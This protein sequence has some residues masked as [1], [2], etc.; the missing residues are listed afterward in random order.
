MTELDTQAKR[1]YE[2]EANALWGHSCHHVPLKTLRA[3]AK[4]ICID[5][6]IPCVTVHV[7]HAKDTTGLYDPNTYRI[8]LEASSGRNLLILAH[9]LA[10]HL[11]W[12]NHPHAQSH[13]PIWAKYYM[14][15]LDALYIMPICAFKAMARQY[16]V[17]MAR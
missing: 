5:V 6:G 13:G 17:R 1:V 8:Q 10:H 15:L 16:G 4:K 2:M 11:T 12:V 3:T 9:E 14:Y 7:R